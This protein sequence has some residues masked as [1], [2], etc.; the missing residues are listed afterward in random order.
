MKL[1]K[2]LI[3]NKIFVFFFLFF[4]YDLIVA[5]IIN[6]KPIYYKTY[7][8]G[9]YINRMEQDSKGIIYYSTFRNIC[10]FDGME[11]IEIYVCQ[12]E[13]EMISGMT[14]INDSLFFWD[15]NKIKCIDLSNY[16]TSQ[17]YERLEEKTHLK[18][19]FEFQGKKYLYKRIVGNC[20]LILQLGDNILENDTLIKLDKIKELKI[21]EDKECLSILGDHH[22]YRY[23]NNKWETYTLPKIEDS[24]IYHNFIYNNSHQI[25]LSCI[26]QG[27]YLFD[28][29]KQEIV[30]SKVS[31]GFKKIHFMGKDKNGLIY[32]LSLLG[33][34]YLKK[35]NYF[36]C[37]NHVSYDFPKRIFGFFCDRQNN[38]WL[39]GR[40]N[41]LYQVQ[42]SYFLG[43]DVLKDKVINQ[44]PL[45]V[46]SVKNQIVIAYTD[47]IFIVDSLFSIKK[48][49]FNS[50][51]YNC[52][53]WV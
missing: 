38:V 51:K 18:E 10:A 34:S 50:S 39:F 27:L 8:T 33:N 46:Y 13:N 26:N 16:H 2:S 6:I 28:L 45:D 37:I 35:D 1:L 53:N 49:Y 17:Y 32:F 29:L 30:E 52:F 14:I 4:I 22:F 25:W 36:H 11:E 12:T 42:N 7:D 31:D 47:T 48:K 43:I 40:W 3:A 9:S 44:R 15:R 21:D 20:S 5:Q 19:L 24:S 41:K 23:F